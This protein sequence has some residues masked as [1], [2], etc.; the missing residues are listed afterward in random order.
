MLA[1]HCKGGMAKAPAG[2]EISGDRSVWDRSVWEP[3]RSRSGRPEA[4]SVRGPEI[5]RPENPKTKESVD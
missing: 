3:K 1:P 4:R 2:V 5:L